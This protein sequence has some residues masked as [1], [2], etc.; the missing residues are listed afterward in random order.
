MSRENSF[1]HLSKQSKVETGGI[2]ALKLNGL[3]GL[4]ACHGGVLV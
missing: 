2:I 1:L 3:V 4:H